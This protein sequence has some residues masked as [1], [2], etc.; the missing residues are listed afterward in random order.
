M[1]RLNEII[2]LL[3]IDVVNYDAPGYYLRSAPKPSTVL[4]PPKKRVYQMFV[5]PELFESTGILGN[6]KV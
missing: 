2:E 5:N 6:I 3:Q 4:F 1:L